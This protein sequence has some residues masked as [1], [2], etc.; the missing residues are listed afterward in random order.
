M[1]QKFILFQ[2][3]EQHHSWDSV[4]WLDTHDLKNKKVHVREQ[5]KNA[6]F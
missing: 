4:N 6:V 1:L 2:L 5:W 3:M